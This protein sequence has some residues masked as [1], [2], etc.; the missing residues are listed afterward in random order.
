MYSRGLGLGD[1]S[2]LDGEGSPFLLEQ[3]NQCR[4]RGDRE[5]ALGCRYVGVGGGD[6]QQRGGC[7]FYFVWFRPSPTAAELTHTRWWCRA[8]PPWLCCSACQPRSYTVAAR[9]LGASLGRERQSKGSAPP[10]LVVAAAAVAGVVAAA[11]APGT[12]VQG[13]S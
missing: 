2:V 1:F 10:L 9:R 8:E 4:V 6:L 12:F 3:F 13:G 5:A 11:P 7:C